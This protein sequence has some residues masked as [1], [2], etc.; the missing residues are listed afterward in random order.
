MALDK[1]GHGHLDVFDTSYPKLKKEEIV[2][3]SRKQLYSETTIVLYGADN[4]FSRPIMYSIQGGLIKQWESPDEAVLLLNSQVI[5]DQTPIRKGDFLSLFRK[6]HKSDGKVLFKVHVETE[7]GT[8][9]VTYSTSYVTSRTFKFMQNSGTI[10][11][12]LIK[13]SA[14]LYLNGKKITTLVNQELQKGD[15]IRFLPST[16]ICE[17]TFVIRSPV[18]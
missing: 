18:I 7:A 15:E 6:T 10:V 17:F 13:P 14:E 1:F 16:N 11:S 9:I 3:E 4:F 5:G 12:E 8:A 2:G